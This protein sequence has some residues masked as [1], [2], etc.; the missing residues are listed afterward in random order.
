MKTKTQPTQT[1]KEIILTVRL[2][3]EE[4]ALLTTIQKELGNRAFGKLSRSKAAISSFRIAAELLFKK[5]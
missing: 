2:S 4:D 1:N 3:A 5:N